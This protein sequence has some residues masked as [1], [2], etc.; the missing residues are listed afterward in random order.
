MLHVCVLNGLYSIHVLYSILSESRLVCVST[1]ET[2]V[3]ESEYVS[4]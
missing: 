4:R 3:F 1:V 2:S